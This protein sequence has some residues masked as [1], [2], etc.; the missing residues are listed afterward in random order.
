M[1]EL[2]LAEK[3]A[4]DL[5]I[6]RVLQAVAERT[7]TP[8]GHARTL[9]ALPGSLLESQ[10]RNQEGAE[11]L[12]LA[13]DGEALPVRS[14]DDVREAIKRLGASGVLSAQELRAVAD[15]LGM[16]RTL[17]RFFSHRKERNLLLA[18]EFSSDPTLD[19]VEDEIKRCF[20]PDGTLAD[21]ASPRLKEQR[22]E[23]RSTR[24]RLLLRLDSVM[25][26]YGQVL[27]DTYVTE[28]EGRY[29]LPVRS[30]SH[31][32][33][34]GIVHTTSATGATLFVEP[35][36]IVPMGNRLK[37]LEGEIARE[38]FIVYST[39]S[40]LLYE[41][42]GSV[43]A[44]VAAIAK[45]DHLAAI[46]KLGLDLRLRYPGF[47]T[48]PVLNILRARH[49]LLLL[50]HWNERAP[51]GEP[52]ASAQDRVVPSDLCIEAGKALVVSGP[53]AGG[54]TVA[55]KTM[56]LAA[57]MARMGLP[58]SCLEGSTVGFFENILT[59]VGD[60]QNIQKNLSTFSAHIRNMAEI[61]TETT[62]ET[63][64]LLD[65]LCGGTDPREGEAL[66]A[67]ILDSLCARGGAVVVTT[68]YEGLKALAVSDTR[69]RNASVGFDQE[70]LAPTFA[71]QL[72]VPGRSSALAVARRHG[73]PSTVI[74]RASKFLAQDHQSFEDVVR[75]LNEERAGLELARAALVD[76]EREL[77]ETRAAIETELQL[78][79]E[80][81]KKALDEDLDGLFE[82]VRRARQD[83]YEAQAILREKRPEKEVLRD[84]GKRLDAVSAAVGSVRRESD[85]RT[86]ELALEDPKAG[87]RVRLRKLGREGEILELVGEKHARI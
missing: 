85:D 5:E 6:T 9:A 40:A 19:P 59:D 86:G 74:E 81:A 87:M 10:A 18:E 79:K 68:H 20:D 47:V 7:C 24:E 27:Q 2:R 83:L 26:K 31:E 35:R 45:A 17:R 21:H 32:R 55:L 78:A 63:L 34:P 1:T 3:A 76:R 62:P 69:F 50:D 39:L 80:R 52:S 82:R 8:M 4:L 29:V 16:A 28:R 58:I 38:E 65:E 77:R 70:A 73:L 67:G 42:L 44:A 36:I 61:L 33:F 48:L 51:G 30:D 23:Y 56:G 57:L 46:A 11:A 37:M 54:K 53:N 13:Q 84:V 75:R 25:Q 66:A 15:V 22:A 72:D 14:C 60:D 12:K 71:L 64:I 43:T 49:P 41:K